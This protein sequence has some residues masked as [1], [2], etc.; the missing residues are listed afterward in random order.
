MNMWTYTCSFSLFRGLTST[1][2]CL[3]EKI[4]LLPCSP[5]KH[6]LNE[7]SAEVNGDFFFLQ[8]LYDYF[9]E[10]EEEEEERKN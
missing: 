9:K 4:L 8:Q 1:L 7:Q 3:Y 2:S 6:S 10:K 5:I